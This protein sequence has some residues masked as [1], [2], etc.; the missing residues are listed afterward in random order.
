[1]RKKADKT[2]NFL[3]FPYQYKRLG[4]AVLKLPENETIKKSL[5]IAE[6]AHA[7][8]KRDEGQPYIIH[9]IR[10][11]NILLY[12]LHIQKSEILISG[13]L[14]DV[15]EDSDIKLRAIQ[16]HFGD[17]VASLVQK[18]T[19]D[20]K[21]ETKEQKFRKIIQETEEVRLLKSIDCL[22]NMRS[23]PYRTLHD[24]RYFRHLEEIHALY[25]PLAK[26]VHPFI[27]QEMKKVLSILKMRSL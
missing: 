2:N 27:V 19:R 5:K 23:F 7:G 10:V 14:H 15:I 25:L 24:K 11:A 20:K 1:L 16:E 3:S 4:K 9:P 8:Q 26:S 18:L 21:T 13:I 17:H 6:K 12:E 22:D